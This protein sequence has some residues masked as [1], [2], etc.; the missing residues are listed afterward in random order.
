M[1]DFQNPEIGGEPLSERHDTGDCF[2]RM[3]GKSGNLAAD[4]RLSRGV[5][6]WVVGGG[7]RALAAASFQENDNLYHNRNRD[8][9]P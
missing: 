1:V 9:A 8:H 6:P 2:L 5:F 3:I 7:W 4:F